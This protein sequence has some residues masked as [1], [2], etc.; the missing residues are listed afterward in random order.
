MLK[1]IQCDK[2]RNK[3][4]IFHS[5]LNVVIGDDI[6]SNS[7]GKST[8]L[9]II[10]FAFGGYDY[11]KTNKDAIEQL[12]HHR[13][14]FEFDF[15]NEKL[16]FS[17]DTKTYL[18]VEVCDEAF[19]VQSQIKLEDYIKLLQ[20]KYHCELDGLTF[21]SV[22]GRY[23]RIYGKENLNEHKPIQYFEKER[24]SESILA[25]VKIFDKYTFLK[26]YENQ[27]TT[28]E[29][30][31][32]ILTN[33][34]KKELI[35]NINKISFNENLKRIDELARQLEMIKKDI[36]SATTDITA[37]VSKEI[38]QLQ[39]EKSSLIVK[40]NIF[41]ARLQRV[42]ANLQNKGANFGM[43]L[44]QFMLFF[45]DFNM[46]KVKEIDSFHEKL[47]HN[48]ASELKSAQKELRDQ[49]TELDNQI[50]LIEV[51]IAEKLNI[52]NAPKFAVEKIIDLS[53]QIN[54]LT[55]ENTF[56]TKKQNIEKNLKIAKN[57]FETLKEGVLNEIC[58]QINTKM[59][60]LNKRIYGDTRRA[61]TL[62]IYGTR[63]SFSTY[64]DTGTGTA[65]VNLI[66]F[67]LAMLALTC[68]PAIA[69]DLPL[70]KN[71]ENP[72]LEKL[73]FLYAASKK[74]VFIAID[75][76]HSYDKSAYEIIEKEGVVHL[77]KE[78]TLFIKNWKNT[79]M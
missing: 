19:Q 60:E 68:L 67:D 44:D 38:L 66:T 72:A 51:K 9:M 53:A 34:T 4:I 59:F 70:L 27:I 69:H 49:I 56:F 24:S 54:Q 12:G 40:R 73:I 31:K 3:E 43:E 28:L 17:R 75:K 71:I 23:F 77:S 22:V 25:L 1:K 57:D 62:N 2:F 33:A 35:P 78:N 79:D 20:I 14:F 8:L 37:L 47:T 15:E 5:G 21:R 13:F 42:K 29:D 48:L 52:K 58:N 45:P 61:P 18:F 41:S 76:I 36:I 65:Y 63:Y 55:S 30:Q 46:E 11:I 50:A 10:D 74:Q 6:A 64:G 32:K 39:K 26:A 16:Y 7:I